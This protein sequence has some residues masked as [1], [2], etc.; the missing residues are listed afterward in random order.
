MPVQTLQS[1]EA[2]KQL[3]RDEPGVVLLLYFRADWCQPCGQ[4]DVVVESL[5]DKH[6]PAL[7]ALK[8]EAEELSD[9]SEA[10]SVASVPTFVLVRGSRTLDTF[11]GADAPELAKRVAAALGSSGPAVPPPAPKEDLNTR[12]GKLVTS[13]PIML[14]M[15][16]SPEQPVC[17]F[18]RQIVQVLEHAGAA[19]GTY[20]SFNILADEEVRQGLKEFSKWPTF[21]Q[22]Y[23]SGQLVGGLDIAKEMF[24]TGDLQS[25]IAEA[26]AGATASA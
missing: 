8:V 18:S 16:G 17:G 3:Q 1:A 26:K 23:I 20:G 9:V 19:P 12:L 6:K 15:K 21:P 4:M 22:L 25:M 5:E 10:Y 14:F 2:L 11:V 13:A 7:K 24:E